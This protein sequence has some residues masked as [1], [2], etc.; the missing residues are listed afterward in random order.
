MIF[1]KNNMI[2]YRHIYF[3]LL[4]ATAVSNHCF[5]ANIDYTADISLTETF[6]D[7]VDLEDDE[8]SN[9]DF[10]TVI[11]PTLEIVSESRRIQSRTNYLL[12][13]IKY[14]NTHNSSFIHTVNSD[15]SIEFIEGHL[16]ADVNFKNGQQNT[17]ASTTE[18][19]AADNL[20]N[21]SDSSGRVNV[22]S[23]QLDPYWKQHINNL[24]EITLG[25]NFNEII[26][27]NNNSTANKTYVNIT[28]GRRISRL[29]FDLDFENK[30]VKNEGNDEIRFRNI[31]NKI[32]YPFTRLFS[33]V[34]SIGFDD[35][36]FE[37]SQDNG[38][39]SWS[40]GG[41]WH[42]SRRTNLELT[43]GERYFGTDL[44]IEGSYET[45]RGKIRLRF[46]QIPETTRNSLLNQQSLNLRD[47]FGE[48]IIDPNTGNPANLDLA[49]IDQ[50]NEVIVN[51][52][53][54]VDFSYFRKRNI[55][56]LSMDFSE[57]EFQLSGDKEE[58]FKTTVHWHRFIKRNLASNVVLQHQNRTL[59]N[60]GETS[61]Y[62][63]DYSLKKVLGKQFGIIMGLRHSLFE[64]DVSD[65]YL[66]NRANITVYKTF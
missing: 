46:E 47:A 48:V 59:I 2:V 14:K 3:F 44:K 57:R 62:I 8:F 42:P 31:N 32:T 7:N 41:I 21:G 65:G 25:N 6:T 4:T 29:L 36:Q 37:S 35:N 33:F 51:N 5:A 45:S 49:A 27:D 39:V 56:N 28:N 9:G 53:F 54:Q 52:K 26:S 60:G 63:V 50:R 15:S 38:G 1:N 23:Y 24:V 66:E 11:S 16:F 12:Q 40:L 58:I 30:I 10:I 19:L 43:Y 64:S 13:G 61:N 34:A 55:F 20:S 22:F 18:R 17:S